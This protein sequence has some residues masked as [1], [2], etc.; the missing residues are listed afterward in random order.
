MSDPGTRGC[1]YFDGL[2]ATY[3]FLPFVHGGGLQLGEGGGQLVGLS[4]LLWRDDPERRQDTSISEQRA[5]ADYD[6]TG[7]D[8]QP[9][10]L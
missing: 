3:H 10:F 5:T 6:V 1:P 8:M 4:L 7:E 2:R 9:M